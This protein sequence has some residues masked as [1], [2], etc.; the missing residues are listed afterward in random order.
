MFCV[1]ESQ[2]KKKCNIERLHCYIVNLLRGAAI[3]SQIT[4]LFALK[5]KSLLF[6]YQ[7]IGR[8]RDKNILH[9]SRGFWAPEN[10]MRQSEWEIQDLKAG[11]GGK[12][13]EQLERFL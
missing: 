1:T 10:Y 12:A 4:I 3:I 9:D 7:E 13:D 11:Q 2:K 5:Y 8:N 6:C